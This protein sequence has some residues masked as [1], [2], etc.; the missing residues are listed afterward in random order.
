[1][2]IEIVTNQND[3]LSIWIMDADKLSHQ[4]RPVDFGAT[5]GYLEIATTSQR[6]KE[7]EDVCRSLARVLIIYTLWLTRL[8]WQRCSP[9]F[10]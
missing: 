8:C 7:N 1:M 9:F 2:G 4:M 5:S 3:P 6:F 10:D